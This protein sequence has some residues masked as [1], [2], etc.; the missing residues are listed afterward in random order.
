MHKIILIIL[1][2][3]IGASLSH[4]QEVDHGYE[5]GSIRFEGNNELNNDQLL[6]VIR[7]RET[8]WAVWKWIYKRFD[9]EILGGQRPVFF[10]PII[11]ASDYQNLKS[12]YADNGF[13]HAHVDSSIVISPDNEK[14]LL[15]FSIA[16]GRR[17]LID[18]IVYEGLAGLPPDMQEELSLNK[19]ITL[20]MPYIRTNVEAEYKRIVGLCM[21]NGYMNMKLA[22]A[23][24]R[25]YASTDNI[26]VIFVFK[27]GKRFTFGKISVEQDTASQ[28]YINSTV[29]LEHL[30]FSAGEYYG[31]EKRIESERNLNR[32]GIFESTKIENTIPDSS[33][34]ITQIPVRIL[35][36]TRPFQELTPE[37]GIN[38]EN[39]AF[40]VLVGIGYNNRNLFGGAENFTTNLRLNVQSLQIGKILNGNML[41]DSSLISKAE[42]TTQLVWPYFINNKT[43]ISAAAS[44]M[45]DKQSTYYIPSISF[46]VGTQSQTATYTRLFVDWNL[47]LSDPQTVTTLKDTSIGTEWTK[48][49][50]SF[51]MVTLQR[52]KRNDIF[53][54]SSGIF[55][56][57]SFE[58]GGLF[59]RA[60]DRPLGLDLPYSQYVK[61]TLDGQWYW[62]PSNKRDLIWAARF[63]TGGAL[64]YGGSPLKDIPL[65]QRY[66]SGGSGSVRG[67]R[68]R[69]LG[70]MADTL[71]NQGGDAM[72]EGTIEARL[73][74]FKRGS[75][76]FLDL[77]K[78]SFVL[79]YDC[80][81]IWSKPGQM[82]LSEIAMA[83]GVGIR[84]NTIA[85][86]IRID[87]GMKLYDPDPLASRHW[88]TQKRFFP[89]TLKQGVIHLGVGHT[90]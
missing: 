62:D 1:L 43:S 46:R 69:D 32:L 22:A 26:S 88:I 68:A 67:W 49:F 48:Q 81:N 83:F 35:V 8:P 87:F 65:T 6:N 17:S 30:D 13:F 41:R 2:I 28:Q 11:F 40:N 36:R 61:L 15:T 64:L 84:Y 39:N 73:N 45:L 7:T 90:F 75:L 72:F 29:V 60:F 54:P 34:G 56:S 3:S 74:P 76:G 58:E 4:A 89:E 10:D 25:H 80:G 37:V 18:T 78:L 59:P 79:F 51:I 12:F 71:R 57:I 14:V 20:G 9:K 47:Q 5:V 52:D 82:R 70:A 86:P 33:S 63:R 38:D 50:N 53:Y 23:D 42:L 44:L 66:Y 85:G 55:Q 31:E 21:N 77:E 24:A 19:Q 27:L 16:E